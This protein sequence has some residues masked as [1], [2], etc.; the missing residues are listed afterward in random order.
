MIIKNLDTLFD[1]T[2][3]YIRKRNLD[4]CRCYG[5]FTIN[6]FSFCRLELVFFV[7][8]SIYLCIFIISTAQTAFEWAFICIFNRK[9][10]NI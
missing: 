9:T 6:L 4:I 7:N 3:G 2:V 8:I 10:F 5:Q 1:Y